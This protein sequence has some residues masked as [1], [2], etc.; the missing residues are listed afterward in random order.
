MQP[1]DI[2]P[3]T[4]PN[5]V[6]RTGHGTGM[7][8]GTMSDALIAYHVARAKGG[9]GLTILEHASVHQSAYTFLNAGALGLVDGYR[10]L[11]ELVRPYGMRVFQQIGHLGNAIPQLDGSPPWSSSDTVAADLGVP[12]EPISKQRI[13]EFVELYARAACDCAAGGLDGVELHMAHGYLVQQFLSPLH[14]HR[15][16]EYGGSFENRMRFAIELATAVRS[17][18]P[19]NMVT[20]VRLGS[21]L[22]EGGMGPP[23][24]A[25]VANR[26]HALQL[27]DY[28]NLTMGTGYI[29]HKVVG[30][31]HEPTGYELPTDVPVK[32][33]VSL[34]VIVTGRFRTLEEADQVVGAGDADMVALT[35]AHIADAD[36]V[37]KTLDGRVEDVRPCIGCNHG[38]IGGLFETGRMGCA[39]NVAVGYEATL[40]EEL[41]TRSASPKR[42]LVIGGGPAGLEAARVAA[43]KGHQVILAEAT[44][45]LGGSINI[46]RRAPRRIGIGDI[47]DWLERQVYK[48]GVEVRLGTY[49]EVAEVAEIEPDVVILATGSRPRMDGRQYLVPNFVAC[50]MEQSHVVS[51]HDLFLGASDRNWGQSAIVYDDVGHYEGVAAAEFLIAQGLAVTFVTSQE[52]FAPKVK[53]SLSSVPALER[54]S[55]GNF[56]LI[57]YGKLLN[58]GTNEAEVTHRYG[59]SP[60]T[61]PGDTVVFIS[62]NLPNRELL[63]AEIDLGVEI[64]PV[65]DVRSPRFLQ[66]A[67]REGHLTARGI[68]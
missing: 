52:S 54:L 4:V 26:L 37:R 34:P 46:A 23:E 62:H 50:G 11:T 38:C 58:I 57:T 60:F 51:S 59:G 7:G 65:G 53:S 35:R 16:D 45:A 68:N 36:L 33:A 9:V 28:V 64:L 67:I 61:V 6:V 47:T 44:G 48:L 18:L 40:S 30:G 56:R 17:A 42:V 20:G 8:G 55:K 27:I 12:A 39:V 1:I 2:G 32:R 19:K 21:E 14:N 63:D 15:T 49:V 25:A 29:L 41:I 31:M 43:L 66:T 5:R 22:I 3:I 24:V 10:K 13:S